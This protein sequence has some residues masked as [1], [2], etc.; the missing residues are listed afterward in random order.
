MYKI[1]DDYNIFCTLTDELY[2]SDVFYRKQDIPKNYK[3]FTVLKNDNAISRACVIYNLELSYQNKKTAQIG[4]FES[5]DDIEAVKLLFEEIKKYCKNQNFEYLIGPINGSTFQKY[6]ITLKSENQPFFLD[7]YN[8]PY[9]SDLFEKCGFETIANYTSRVSKNLNRNYSRLEKFEKIYNKNGITIRNFDINNFDSELDKIYE[10]S[11]E[12]FKNNFL[13]TPIHYEEF[14]MMYK[15]IK[16]LVNPEW[17]LF[18]QDETGKPLAFVFAFD[19]LYAQNKKSLVVKTLAKIS[20]SK[21]NGI[22][23]YL[24]ELLHYKAYQKNYDEV[25]HALMYEDNV[26]A[27]IYGKDSEILQRYKLYGVKL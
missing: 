23:T 6:R 27:N 5:Y 8:K 17:I 9:Y 16:N 26:S 21:A 2:R 24:T 18:A 20:N 3:Y 13:Y 1:T 19:N 10:V 22:G 12:S 15:P 25:I 11:V 7:N 4:Y 14:K